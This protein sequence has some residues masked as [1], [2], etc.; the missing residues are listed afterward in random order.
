MSVLYVKVSPKGRSLKET[1]EGVS[2]EETKYVRVGSSGVDLNTIKQAAGFEIGA[3]G[4]GDSICKSISVK[5]SD[6]AGLLYEVTASYE[7]KDKKDGEDPDNPEPGELPAMVWSASGSSSTVP[8]YMDE[9]GAIIKNSAGDPVEDLEKEQAEFALTLSIPY[10]THGQFLAVAKKYVDKCNNGDW[11]GGAQHTWLCRFRS[12]Q[13]ERK[14]GIVYW[15]A[16]F[17]FA[18]R[19]ETWKLMPWDLGFHEMF[20]GY[21]QTGN[22]QD[23]AGKRRTILGEDGKPIK[24]P[25][26]LNNAGR[27]LAPGAAPLVINNGQGVKVYKEENFGAAFGEIFTPRF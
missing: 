9:G 11:N 22:P 13:V 3:G 1:P 21:D 5:A 18:Y 14:S 16:S 15:A 2:V 19:A 23:G 27:P 4:V 6:D 17:E 10:A 8:C 20:G 12:A 7:P 26:A 25:V 24:Q